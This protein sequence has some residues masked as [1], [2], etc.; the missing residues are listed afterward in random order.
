MK[1]CLNYKK[2]DSEDIQ[3]RNCSHFCRIKDGYVGICG[4]RKNIGG[5]LNLLAYGKAIALHIDSIEKK[6][7]FHFLPGSYAYSFGSFGCNFRCDNCQNYDIS[8]MFDY[9]GRERE[10]HKFDWSFE[11]SPEEIVKEA[12]KNNC[13][14]IAYTYN[15]PTVFLEY[16]LDTM[17]LAKEKGLKNIWVSNGYMSREALDSI[18]PWLDAINIDIKSYDDNFYKT[19]CGARLEP[20]LENCEYLA[21]KGV[22]LEITTLVIPGLSD[23]EKMLEGIAG[24]I[25]RELGDFVPWH[26][27]VFSAI[28]SWKLQHL[29]D[30]PAK[31]I[32]KAREIGR[33]EGLKYVYAGNVRDGDLKNTQ[34]PDCQKNFIKRIAYEVS[35]CPRSGKCEYCGRKIEGVFS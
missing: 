24:F 8:Q 5:K 10:Y 15:E 30:T 35:E 23:D 32:K 27:N 33:K 11:I 20:V 16:A 13:K 7:L 3:C 2:I 29:G 18:L 34:C 9:K 26:V 25:K 4:I 17:K 19:N 14:S 31:T 1:E 6:P 12:V 28:I 21:E 22:W